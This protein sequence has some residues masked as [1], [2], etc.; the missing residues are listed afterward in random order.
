MSQN[1]LFFGSICLTDLIELAK[2]KHS[3]FTKGNNGKIYCAVNVWLNAETD[4]YGNIMSIQVNPTKEM[5]DIDGR[6]YIGNLKESD[7]PKPISSRDANHIDD[8]FDIPT[9]QP[10]DV[11]QY[12]NDDAYS[13]ANWDKPNQPGAQDITEPIQDLPF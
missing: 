2:K 3:A 11:S 10:N 8:D 7:K 13:A 1:Q 4:K 9:R 5:K 6:P 12:K